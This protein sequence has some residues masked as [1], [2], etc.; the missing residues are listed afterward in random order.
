MA[1]FSRKPQKSNNLPEA[2]ITEKVGRADLA[3]FAANPARTIY[4]RKTV[5]G[6]H[7]KLANWEHRPSVYYTDFANGIFTFPITI[8]LV[9]EEVSFGYRPLFYYATS[10]F[11]KTRASAVEL[12]LSISEK[13]LVAAAVAVVEGPIRQWLPKD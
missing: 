9:G 5:E 3:W 13:D 7:G 2:D 6:E 10:V 12:L 1:L 8:V 11:A 4:A